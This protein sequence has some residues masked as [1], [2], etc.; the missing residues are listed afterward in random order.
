[1]NGRDVL[2]VLVALVA[3]L[4]GGAV[5]SWVLVS[6]VMIVQTPPL[7]AEVI[8]AE[9]FEVVS[10]DGKIRAV[11]GESTKEVFKE[12]IEQFGLA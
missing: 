11:L 3:G 1:M 12:L 4:V 10:K 2:M 5:S 7:P 6:R 8:R 9:R